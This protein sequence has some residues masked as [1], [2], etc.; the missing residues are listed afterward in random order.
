MAPGEGGGQEQSSWSQ[1]IVKL[2]LL[3]QVDPAED[4]CGQG[5]SEHHDQDCRACV[6][7]VLSLAGSRGEGRPA[8]CISAVSLA[9]LAMLLGT[10]LPGAERA[11][12]AG[13]SRRPGSLYS[14]G[15][16]RLRLWRSIAMRGSERQS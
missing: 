9:L 6:A 10:T 13:G 14:C 16:R 11:T 12:G 3:S 7:F 1:L 2:V 15:W 8:G 5:Q 4:E